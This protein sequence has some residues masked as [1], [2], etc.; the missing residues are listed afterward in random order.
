M[1]RVRTQEKIMKLHFRSLRGQIMGGYLEE[2]PG[3]VPEIVWIIRTL[4]LEG[5]RTRRK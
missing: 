1:P 3:I 5:K 2:I 4:I